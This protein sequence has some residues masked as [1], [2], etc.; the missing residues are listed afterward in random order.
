MFEQFNCE[1]NSDWVL[2]WW[3]MGKKYEFYI[4]YL[5]FSVIQVKYGRVKGTDGIEGPLVENISTR[6]VLECSN[7]CV[8]I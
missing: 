3:S 2:Q 7:R 8:D 6:S 4:F 5:D 1:F